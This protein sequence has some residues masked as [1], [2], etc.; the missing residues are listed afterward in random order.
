MNIKSEIHYT[1]EKYVNDYWKIQTIDL[2]DEN[3]AME[4]FA[5]YVND[6]PDLKFRVVLTETTE[7]IIRQTD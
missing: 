2:Y 4:T 3:K 1:V 6:Y 5:H 7:T